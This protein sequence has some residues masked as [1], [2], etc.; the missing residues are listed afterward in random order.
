MIRYDA[1]CR[2]I[3]DRLI[4]KFLEYYEGSIMNMSTR[5]KGLLTSG[6]GADLVFVAYANTLE[7][8]AIL[9]KEIQGPLSIAAGLP[10]NITEFSINDLI[11]LN[12][13]RISLPMLMIQSSIQGMLKSLRSISKSNSFE[14][15]VNNELTC[16]SQDITALLNR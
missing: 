8:V 11:E 13:A 3:Q 2:F 15:I 16:S 10:Y 14:D 6:T 4:T 5:L 7:E 1:I 9:Q 12:L